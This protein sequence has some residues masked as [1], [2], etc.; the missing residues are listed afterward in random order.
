LQYFVVEGGIILEQI[1]NKESGRALDGLIW[2]RIGTSDRVFL[3][4]PLNFRFYK[5][6]IF[7]IVEEM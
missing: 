4:W 7:R 1:F 3:T 2:L 6:R 5:I